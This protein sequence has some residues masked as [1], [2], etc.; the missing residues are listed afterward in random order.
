VVV[1]FLAVITLVAVVGIRIAMFIAV[2]VRI[3][4]G[5]PGM[6]SVLISVGVVLSQKRC[7]S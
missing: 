3:M 6:C 2:S 4:L 5:V 1:R 7:S